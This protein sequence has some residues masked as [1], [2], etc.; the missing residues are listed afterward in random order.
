[1]TSAR[2]TRLNGYFEGV[3]RGSRNLKSIQDANL[4]IEA[5]CVQPD[6]PTCAEKI[7]STPEGL[8]SLQACMRFTTASD[9]LNG[10]ATKLFQYIGNPSIKALCDGDYLAWML[11]R[12]VNPPIFWNAFV[13]DYLHDVLS[14]QVVCL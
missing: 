12:I 8:Q 5:I 13:F 14:H 3:T 10:S 2:T 4:F 11:F 7:V 6:P 1:M 9:F